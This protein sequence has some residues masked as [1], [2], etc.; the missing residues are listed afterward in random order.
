MGQD[1]NVDST[2]SP[3]DNE[4]TL[5]R[6]IAKSTNDVVEGGGGEVAVSGSTATTSGS[7]TAGSRGLLLITS[8]DFTGTIA[9]ATVGADASISIAPP[10]GSKI[11]A[12]AYVITTGS[13][14]IFDLR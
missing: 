6:K 1:Y 13:I 2:P 3:S 9:G 14:N 4:V 5:L 12:V 10:N 7:T 11:G 8:S